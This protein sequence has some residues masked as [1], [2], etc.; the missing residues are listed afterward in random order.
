MPNLPV[1]LLIGRVCPIFHRL[2]N[3]EPGLR[4][5]RPRA[6]ATRPF[7]PTCLLGSG[8]QS[9]PVESVASGGTAPHRRE[10]QPA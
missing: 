9:F 4:P 2:W 1:P 6:E 7:C 8:A 10:H 5:P 3:P